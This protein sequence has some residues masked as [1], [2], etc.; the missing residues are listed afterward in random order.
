MDSYP[1]IKSFGAQTPDKGGYGKPFI[2]PFCITGKGFA[3][4][5]TGIKNGFLLANLVTVN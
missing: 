5:H 3:K 4:Q 1:A 2:L